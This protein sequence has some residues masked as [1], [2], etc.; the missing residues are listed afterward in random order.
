MVESSIPHRPP[1]LFVDR[2]EEM[3]PEGITGWRTLREEEPHFA[4][5]YPG[6]PIMPGVLL[7]EAAF[8]TAAIYLAHEHAPEGG[9]EELTPVLA[10]IEEAR[11]KRI[12]RPGDTLKI[13]VTYRERKGGFHFLKAKLSR[14]GET[15]AS[16][17]FALAMAS[18]EKARR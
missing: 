16:L 2:V 12:A 14:E 8:Q 13:E 15:V 11:F 3:S 17:S 18:E 4:G 6:N 5:H 7:C 10:R 1:F 9:S